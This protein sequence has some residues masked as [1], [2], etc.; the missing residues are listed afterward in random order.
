M[1]NHSMAHA[2]DETKSKNLFKPVLSDAPWFSTAK[3]VLLW[4]AILIAAVAVRSVFV[5]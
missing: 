5:K 3:V 2:T 1:N 4:F